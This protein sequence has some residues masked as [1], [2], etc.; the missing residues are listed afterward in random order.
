[1]RLSLGEEGC[2]GGKRQCPMLIDLSGPMPP[3]VNPPVSGYKFKIL[4]N[5]VTWKERNTTRDSGP[6][7]IHTCLTFA[8]R[9]DVVGARRMGPS[10]TSRETLA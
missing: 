8:Q 10:V 6:S 3:P 7:T 2:Q 5:D 9:E 4:C 1:M